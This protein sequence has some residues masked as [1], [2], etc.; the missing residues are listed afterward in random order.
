M[1]ESNGAFCAYFPS[2]ILAEAYSMLLA[3]QLGAAKMRDG[4]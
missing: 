1:F 3:N 2:I 4:L